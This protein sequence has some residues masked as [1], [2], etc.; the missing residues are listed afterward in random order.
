M[1]PLPN[2]RH[3][4]FAAALAD[5]EELMAAYRIAGYRRWRKQAVAL[6]ERPE[7]KARVEALRSPG[8]RPMTVRML[9]EQLTRIARAAEAQGSAT[10]LAVARG[11]WMD[12]A[13]LSGLARSRTTTEDAMR[14]PPPLDWA[15]EPPL[16]EDEWFGTYAP[17]NP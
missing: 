9:I 7:V 1:T 14:T 4:A 2:P 13:R 15:P 16:S 10:G 12:M 8:A 5:G 17:P 3:E 11:A 6:S